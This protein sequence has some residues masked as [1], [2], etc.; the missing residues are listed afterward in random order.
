MSGRHDDG[1]L[2]EILQLADVSGPGGPGESVHSFVGDRFQRRFMRRTQSLT[3]SFTNNGMSSRRSRRGGKAT[4]KMFS[5]K[6]RSLRKILI[7]GANRGIGQA[8]LEEAVASVP[9][10]PA[11][12]ISKAAAFSM[13]QSLRAL[14]A[15][16]GVKVH[17]VF[18]GPAD[19]DMTRHPERFY[20]VRCAGH[21]RRNRKRRGGHLPRS[22]VGVNRRGLAQGGDQGA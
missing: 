21:P 17:A 6:K 1:A 9:F 5:R 7:T 8:L 10:S 13:T 14:W 18:P 19:T 3:N 15:G 20:G 12:A 16:R 4:G 2:D 11:Y 22:D